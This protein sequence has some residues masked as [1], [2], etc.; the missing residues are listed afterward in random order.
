MIGPAWRGHAVLPGNC[1]YVDSGGR[2]QGLRAETWILL[3]MTEGPSTD[4][5]VWYHGG[6]QPAVLGLLPTAWKDMTVPQHSV[7]CFCEYPLSGYYIPRMKPR[8]PVEIRVG[9]GQ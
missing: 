4:G 9:E 8:I 7:H 5:L 2:P 1:C 3:K 6:R